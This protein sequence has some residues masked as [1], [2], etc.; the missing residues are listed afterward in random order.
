MAQG[1][2]G[3]G[4]GLAVQ[5]SVAFLPENYKTVACSPSLSL[6]ILFFSS[7]PSTNPL[8]STHN[9]QHLGSL[10]RCVKTTSLPGPLRSSPVANIQSPDFNILPT[11]LFTPSVLPSQVDLNFSNVL[12]KPSSSFAPTAAIPGLEFNSFTTDSQ[13]STWLPSSSQSLPAVPAHNQQSQN[14]NQRVQP[15]VQQDFVLYDEPPTSSRRRPAVLQ[16][17]VN[18]ALNSN[19]L[20]PRQHHQASSPLLQNQSVASI[21]H[22]TGHYRPASAP[23]NQVYSSFS[24]P[25]STVALNAQQNRANTRPPVPAFPQSTGSIPQQGRMFSGNL[26]PTAHFASMQP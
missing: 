4:G 1:V 2:P 19:Q 3:L 23:A 15:L 8:T 9:Q 5:H 24:A 17:P 10:P 12:S 22:K 7:F 25:Q 20:F 6:P 14:Q 11:Q 26:P 13:P 21:I 18:G 16:S